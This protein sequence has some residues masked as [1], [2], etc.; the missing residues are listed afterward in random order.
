M[1]IIR[2]TESDLTRIVKA[3][4]NEQLFS[5]TPLMPYAYQFSNKKS[6]QTPKETP[7][8]NPKNLKVK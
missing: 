7:N 2:L 5:N 4:M 3:V 1:K 6:Q 8:I